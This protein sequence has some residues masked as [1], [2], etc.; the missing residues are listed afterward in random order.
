MT[1]RWRIAFPYLLTLLMAAGVYWSN[2]R[3]AAP[4]SAAQPAHASAASVAMNDRCP[5]CDMRVGPEDSIVATADGHR[6]RFCSTG[7]RDRFLADHAEGADAPPVTEPASA[8]ASKTRRIDPVCQMEV[9]PAWGFSAASPDG[10]VYFCSQR[11][12]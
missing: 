10:V 5:G 6:W 11:C 12:R 7:C 2:V 9:N 8:A 4:R 3:A 1:A